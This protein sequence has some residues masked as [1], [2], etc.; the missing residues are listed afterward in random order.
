MNAMKLIMTEEVSSQRATRIDLFDFKSVPMRAF[1][2]SW[3]AFFLCFFGWFG[4]A[5]FIVIISEEL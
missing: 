4:V 1:H 3:I 2:F 5:P